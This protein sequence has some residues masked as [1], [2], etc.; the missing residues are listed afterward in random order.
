VFGSLL[1]A[2]RGEIARRVIRT[3]RRLGLRTIAVYSEADRNA[4]HVADADEAVL[5][6]GAAARDS[7]LRIDAILEAARRTGAEAVHPGYGF[8]SEKPDFADALAAAGLIFVGPPASAIRAMGL[9]DAAKDIVA[10]A[11]VPVVPGYQ[12]TDQSPELLRAEAAK[13]G[14]PVLIKAVAGGGGKGMRRVETDAEFVKAL[15]GAKREAAGAFGDDRVL[16]EKYVGRPRHIEIQVFADAHGNAV[17]LFERDCSLQRRHQKVIEEALAPGM[18]GAMRAKMG[19]AAVNAALAIGYR[20]AGTVEFI[21]DSSQGLREDAFFFMEMNTRLQVE[22]PVTEAITGL[23]LV[24]LQLRIAAG[25]SL[26]PQSEIAARGHAIEA[27]L[28]AEDPAKGFLPSIG[29][30]KRL[31]L[32]PEGQGLRIDAGVREGDEVTMFYDPMIAKIIAHGATRDEARLKLARAMEEVE[33]AGVRTN[34]AFVARCL[35]HPGFAA[36]DIDTGF[37]D[38]H[39]AGLAPKRGA[40][41]AETLAIAAL[42]VLLAK[43]AKRDWSPWSV[44]DGFR[45]G[46]D[47]FDLVEFDGEDGKPI[48]V[49]LSRA[50]S[51]WRADTQ[52][53]SFDLDAAADGPHLTVTIGGHRRGAW[54]DIASHDVTLLLSGETW[55]LSLFDPLDVDDAAADAGAS[56]TAPMPGKVVSVSVK[57]GDKVKRGAALAV[58]EA[59]KMEHTLTAP[60]DRE[61]EAVRVQPGDQ[62]TEGTALIV[63]RT[64]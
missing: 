39:I 4:W 27:R 61:I 35:R 8:L 64:A 37:I 30:L 55:A 31:H 46:G 54:L 58:L 26:P 22:H 38:R 17:H 11:G 9:K 43:T 13:T 18:T 49:R 52:G 48:A 44:A 42:G 51:A 62:V 23:D 60:A 53:Q 63:F 28:Y 36:G 15:E 19:A 32:P 41:S 3:A 20:G 25:E 29:T 24:E 10:K 14:Y 7:Y 34:A 2:N 45:V 12:G 1:I 33:A 21:V 47:G 50:D 57:P 5:I 40:P 16:I 6:G 59:M 56:V